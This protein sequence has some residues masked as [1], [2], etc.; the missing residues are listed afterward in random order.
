MALTDKIKYNEVTSTDERTEFISSV[1]RKENRSRKQSSW[2]ITFLQNQIKIICIFIIFVVIVTGLI[3]FFIH[4][5]SSSV[6]NDSIENNQRIPQLRSYREKHRTP[7]S[8]GHMNIYI[9]KNNQ[10]NYH[11]H[12]LPVARYNRHRMP[13]RGPF[14]NFMPWIPIFA[15]RFT[16]QT[17]I[18]SSSGVYILP[19]L[20]N[21]YGQLFSVAQLI[22]SGYASLVSGGSTLNGNIDMLRYFQPQPLIGPGIPVINPLTGGFVGGMYGNFGSFR[23]ARGYESRSN[24]DYPYEREGDDD[25]GY[26]EEERK[27]D[28]LSESLLLKSFWVRPG[29]KGLWKP[30]SIP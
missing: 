22:A 15:D 10:N 14:L 2:S 25:D 16:K 21:T 7:D 6:K 28:G 18:F 1:T 8:L 26:E 12:R 17:I 24:I 3:I 27:T 13:F 23:K 30:F 5:Q 11:Q 29:T 19:P 20:I 9:D 4:S